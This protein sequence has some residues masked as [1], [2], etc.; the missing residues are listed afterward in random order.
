MPF[1]GLGFV[2]TQSDSVRPDVELIPSP[3][4]PEARLW[5]PG[6]RKALGHQIS[7]RVATLHPRSRGQVTLRSADPSAPPRIFWNLLDD[8]QDL[9]AL[10]DGVKAVRDIYNQEPLKSALGG[11]VTPGD[12]ITS[13]AA[14]EE[15]LRHNCWTAAHP[16]G[17]CRMG[18]DA[19]AV[20]D[21][22]L[23]PA[24]W[25]RMPMQWSMVTCEL[26]ALMGYAWPIARLCPA[27][28]VA[29]PMPR[30]S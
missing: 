2:R 28:S 29:I 30:A 10:R 3:I 16:A 24:A 26:T 4:G 20:L 1:G 18:T 25:G 27:W 21:G 6:I 12:D 19:N 14:I 8:P 23:G 9:H 7:C 11:E 15:W 17:T 13:D 22:A 5:F